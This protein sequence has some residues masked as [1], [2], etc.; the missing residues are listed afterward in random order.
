MKKSALGFGAEKEDASYDS[1]KEKVLTEAKR[2]LKPEFINRFDD[3]I[4]FH[5]LLKPDLQQIVD[6]E[7]AK[8]VERLRRK[9][10]KVLL[11]EKARDFLIEKGFDP[12]YGA[13]P[14]R[15]AVERYL[16]D[17]MAEEMLKGAFKA[18]DTAEV[19]ANEK[20][21]VFKSV[22]TAKASEPAPAT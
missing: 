17:P 5:Q 10:I 8:L 2:V 14:M 15:R 6:L 3:L 20:E 4:V 11:D 18:G 13:R 12:A 7:V 22:G 19:T 9:D 1:M 16:E 21:L